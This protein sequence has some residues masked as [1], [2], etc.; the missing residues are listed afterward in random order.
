[1]PTKRKCKNDYK[2]SILV[3]EHRLKEESTVRAQLD[4]SSNIEILK[5]QHRDFLLE[6]NDLENE[7]NALNSQ[8]ERTHS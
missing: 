2:Q 5:E 8:L 3:G 7:N 4:L 1:M 6:L